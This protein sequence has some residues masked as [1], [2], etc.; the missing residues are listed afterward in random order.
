MDD[1]DFQRI[2]GLLID[3]YTNFVL[4]FALRLNSLKLARI[5]VK[6][7]QQHTQPPQAIEFLE[8][9]K[10]LLG[11]AAAIEAASGSRGRDDGGKEAGDGE[12][13]PETEP[14]LFLKSSLGQLYLQSGDTQKAMELMEAGLKMLDKIEDADPCV[15][16]SVYSLSSQYHKVRRA[17]DGGAGGRSLGKW[18][19]LLSGTR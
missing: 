7:S 16:A 9:T 14:T 4:L 12:K 8:Q 10:K 6:V 11:D 17:K 18:T 19:S 1:A 15:I 5:A 2:P 13:E 3:L